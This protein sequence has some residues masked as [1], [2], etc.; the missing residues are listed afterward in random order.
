MGHGLF[1][2][3]LRLL[4]ASLPNVIIGRITVARPAS[5]FVSDLEYPRDIAVDN[6]GTVYFIDG[7]SDIKKVDS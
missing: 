1:L 7:S 6:S 5:V 2:A 3:S 4:F